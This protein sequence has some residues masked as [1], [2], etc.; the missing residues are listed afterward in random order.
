M[1]KNKYTTYLGLIFSIIFFQG[2]S[3]NQDDGILNISEK[4][5][6]TTSPRCELWFQNW[7][8]YQRLLMVINS[9]PI[10]VSPSPY[11]TDKKNKPYLKP[12]EYEKI[13]KQQLK[14]NLYWQEK[15]KWEKGKSYNARWEVD[16]SNPKIKLPRLFDIEASYVDGNLVINVS[17]GYEPFIGME[18]TPL[19]SY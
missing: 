9:D 13:E 10:R 14:G 19:K 17:E 1:N 4:W 11:V 15:P 16:R 18:L 5:T 7:G 12:K 2:C 8:D 6:S 3:T